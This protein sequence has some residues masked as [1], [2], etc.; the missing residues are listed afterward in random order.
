MLLFLAAV[1]KCAFS[2]TANDIGSVYAI[3]VA[4]AAPF[5]DMYWQ[6]LGVSSIAATYLYPPLLP[7]VAGVATAVHA[8][9][10]G[11]FGYLHIGNVVIA[12]SSIAS[13]A[14]QTWQ[15]NPKRQTVPQ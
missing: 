3:W 13:G 6:G 12:A 14:F 5:G 15:T 7:V 10:S 2:Q 8:V 1:A 11:S 4:A 9:I